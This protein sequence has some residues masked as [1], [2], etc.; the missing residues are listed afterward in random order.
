VVL[1]SPRVSGACPFW[2]CV[3]RLFGNV[4]CFINHYQRKL[5]D[6]TKRPE[7]NWERVIRNSK[8]KEVAILYH[9]GSGIVAHLFEALTGD[10]NLNGRRRSIANRSCISSSSRS[11]NVGLIIQDL[12]KLLVGYKNRGESASGSR[13]ALNNASYSRVPESNHW[14]TIKR[15][16]L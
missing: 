7:G 8:A 11:Y 9:V 14:N 10:V 1:G 15:T 4:A 5:H 12:N 2:T 6:C 13:V 3:T 16:A